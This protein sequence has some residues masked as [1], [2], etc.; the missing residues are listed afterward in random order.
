VTPGLRLL[1]M[2][3]ALWVIALPAAPALADAASWQLEAAAHPVSIGAAVSETLWTTARPPGGGQDRIGLHLYRGT[4]P[5][6]AALLYLPGTNMNGAA[7]LTDENHNLWLFLAAR[8]IDVFALD[9][10]THAVSPEADAAALAVMRGWDTAAFLDD[11]KAAS[12][13]AQR[14]SRNASLFVAGFSRGGSMAYAYALTEPEAVAG[15]IILD[16]AYKNPA[17]KP[18]DRAAAMEDLEAKGVWASDVGGRT[19]WAARQALMDAVVTDPD[20]PATDPKFKTVGEQLADKLQNAWGP[21]GL[22]N[23]MGGVSSPRVLATL[24]RGYDRYYPAIQD[25]EGRSVSSQANDPATELDERWGTIAAPVLLFASTGMGGDWLVNAVHSAA[26]SGSRDIT[27]VVLERYG[28]MDVLVAER[29]RQDVFEPALA[30]I[31][32]RA[33]TGGQR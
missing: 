27:Y 31:T 7:A 32:A 21:G 2:A 23:P 18:F 33:A 17:P 20:A 13:L 19:G 9:Y 4:A 5:R 29:A 3:A 11:I 22:A 14:E 8:G 16:S 1:R 10:R 15:L 6:I 25:V 28:H 12:A 30:W 26:A 24:M